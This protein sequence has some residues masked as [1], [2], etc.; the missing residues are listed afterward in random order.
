MSALLASAGYGI[1]ADE[2]E[3]APGGVTPAVSSS[4]PREESVRT[5]SR[6]RKGKNLIIAGCLAQHFQEE[7]L[8][9]LPEAK[10]IVGTG[11]LPALVAGLD[12]WRLRAGHRVSAEPPSGDETWPRYRTHHRGG[13]LLEG[14]RGLRLPLRLC[15]IRSCAAPTRSRPIGSIVAEAHQ[16]APRRQELS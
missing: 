4:R 14:G 3:A 6:W 10:A 8:E 16:L 11:G 7:L 5:W 12:G 9:S 15:I 2:N 1:S 13:R